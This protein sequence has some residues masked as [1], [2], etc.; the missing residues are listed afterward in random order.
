MRPLNCRFQIARNLDARLSAQRA[1]LRRI[2]VVN[3]KV[4][5]VSAEPKSTA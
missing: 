5:L 3:N 4:T 1:Q 2:A